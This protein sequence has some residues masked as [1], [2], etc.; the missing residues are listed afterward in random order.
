MAAC[1]FFSLLEF[2][3]FLGMSSSLMISES[4]LIFLRFMPARMDFGF[5]GRGAGV[6]CS[7]GGI[8]IIWELRGNWWKV[9]ISGFNYEKL[10]I[11]GTFWDFLGI[12]SI[13][14][15][16]L[17]GNRVK[18]GKVVRKFR[19]VLGS[20]FFGRYKNQFSY[21]VEKS[22]K[23]CLACRLDYWWVGLQSSL[24]VQHIRALLVLEEF[25]GAVRVKWGQVAVLAAGWVPLLSAEWAS[26][27]WR[28]PSQALPSSVK[29]R[30]L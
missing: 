22:W 15:G 21:L 16:T 8:A 28:P 7:E 24:E 3:P 9:R 23:G 17:R 13:F 29:V 30:N 4:S 6:G 1:L 12:F 5:E 18:V 11:F 14:W 10:K 26:Q 25:V 2:L 19:D 20:L 27:A